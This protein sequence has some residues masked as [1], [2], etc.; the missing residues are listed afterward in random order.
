[1]AFETNPFSAGTSSPSEDVLKITI[2]GVPLSVDDNE[3]IKMLDQFHVNLTSALKYE[4]IRHPVTRKMT[5]IMNGNRFIYAKPLSDGKFLPRTS[6][7]AGLKCQIFHHGQPSYK[8]KP[9]C[10]NCWQDDHFRFQCKNNK[11]CKV[12]LM[13]GHLPGSELCSA[14]IK[15]HDKVVTFNGKDNPISNFFPC[16]LEAFGVKHRSAE[17]AFQYVKALRCGDLPRASAIQAAQTALDAKNI[18]KQIRTSE[19]FD[20]KRIEIMEEIIIEK[21]KQVK[22]FS[23]TLCKYPKGT[24]FAE[25]T[26]DDFWGTG[27]DK[28]GSDHTQEKKWPGENHLGQL[29][30]KVTSGHKCYLRTW[31]CPQNSA[32]SQDKQVNIT[33]ML[34]PTRV[35]RKRSRDKRNSRDQSSR[36]NSPLKRSKSSRR[37]A[38]TTRQRHT[39]DYDS[40]SSSDG[41]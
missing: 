3:I 34:K 20:E 10:T 12:C 4:K 2:K 14:Y 5:G 26:Y 6:F 29:I 32:K 21:L 37:H 8:R 33:T 1:M 36:E 18:G 24:T 28:D 11:R 13:E 35:S 7:C 39:P 9:R 17:H 15:E 30:M 38:H 40:R 19:Q 22:Q 27:L 25:S 31:S 16:S 23:D 41:D